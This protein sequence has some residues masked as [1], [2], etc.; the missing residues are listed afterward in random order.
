MKIPGIGV[1]TDRHPERTFAEIDI[2]VLAG[3]LGTRARPVLGTDLPKILAPIGERSFLEVVID[4]VRGYGARRLVLCLG[5]LAS[6]VVD[7]VALLQGKGLEIV[8]VIEPKPLGTGGALR[9]ASPHLSSEPV[10]VMNGDSWTNA[11]LTGFLA[12]H[13]SKNSFLT[14]LCVRMADTSRYGRVDLAAD[15]SIARFREKEPFSRPG[16]INA[17]IY[18]LSQKALR[19]LE[20][21]QAVSFERD[22]LES[23]AEGR[24]EAYVCDDADFIDIGVPESYAAAE[25]VIGAAPA[26]A[27]P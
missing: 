17:G 7:R 2:A 5:H 15:G 21:S 4:W 9:F 1:L 11:D 25:S 16:L 18:L 19:E 3:G 23:G 6:K 22:F 8:T 20:A 27:G 26:K 14:A 24:I 13:R 12:A 10:L